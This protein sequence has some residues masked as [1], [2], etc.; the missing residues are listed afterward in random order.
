V[1]SIVLVML[2]YLSLSL[3]L[4]LKIGIF[5]P[6]LGLLASNLR[7]GVN[8]ESIYD[9]SKFGV[10]RSRGCPLR[11]LFSIRGQNDSFKWSQCSMMLVGLAGEGA[12][13]GRI[14][15]SAL[16]AIIGWRCDVDRFVDACFSEGHFW[17]KVALW[18]T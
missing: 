10:S 16:Q 12:L 15:K 1:D 11:P 17:P 13:A 2:P 9:R 8:L 7:S 18:L 6:F 4:S 14:L 3:S 5:W